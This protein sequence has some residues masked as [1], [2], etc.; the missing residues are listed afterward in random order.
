MCFTSNSS[1]NH[2]KTHAREAPVYF[3]YLLDLLDLWDYDTELCQTQKHIF[4]T[5]LNWQSSATSN[6]C[7]DPSTQPLLILISEN[8]G[9]NKQNRY[10]LEMEVLSKS[11]HILMSETHWNTMQKL[12]S[13]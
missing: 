3:N 2:S 7:S 5:Q 12:D 6:C 10:S 8:M 11:L 4:A 13:K 9:I 1:H